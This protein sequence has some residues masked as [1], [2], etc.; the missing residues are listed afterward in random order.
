MKENQIPESGKFFACGTCNLRLWNL[1]YSSRNSGVPLTI[2][3]WNVGIRNLESKI[4]L[5]SLTWGEKGNVVTFCMLSERNH[6]CLSST[7]N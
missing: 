6:N 7:A 3:I 1:E 4:V 5:N 2:G